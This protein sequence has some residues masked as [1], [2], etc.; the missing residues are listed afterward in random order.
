M[1]FG[2]A[3]GT[4]LIS[5]LGDL[6]FSMLKRRSKIKDTGQIFPGHGGMLDRI[7]SLIAALPLFYCGLLFL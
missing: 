5:M 4:A 2:I 6:F 7:D 3:I 1:W